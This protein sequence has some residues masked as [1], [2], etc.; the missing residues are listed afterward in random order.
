M[1]P[2]NHIAIKRT[3]LPCFDRIE[4]PTPKKSIKNPFSAKIASFTKKWGHTGKAILISRCLI[5]IIANIGEIIANSG[6]LIAKGYVKTNQVIKDSCVVLKDTAVHLKFFLIVNIPITLASMC[7]EVNNAWK[8]IQWKDREGV[9]LSTILFTLSSACLFD[10][11]TVFVNATLQVFAENSVRWIA[12]MASPLGIAITSVSALTKCYHLYQLS[13]F[14]RELDRKI[15]AIETVNTLKE[16]ISSQELRTFL[17]PFLQKHLGSDLSS[18]KKAQA[19]LQRHTSPEVANLMK[20]IADLLDNNA[21]LSDEQIDKVL[22]L[23][24]LIK[25]AMS[26][27]KRLQRGLLVATIISGI[28]FGLLLTPA[29]LVA[30]PV[31]LAVSF[32]MQI[33]LKIDHNK[34]L[35]QRLAIA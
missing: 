22:N 26:D 9:A 7:S 11:I 17:C 2:I 27:E 13:K 1:S 18:Q 14:N 5:H 25:T 8:S 6:E 16:K 33:A 29:G 4:T 3:P 35:N 31:L 32:S 10:D 24:K 12:E 30:T 21:T 15:L 28:A 19:I 23:L 20:K 34:R